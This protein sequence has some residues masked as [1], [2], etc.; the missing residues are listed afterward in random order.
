LA[1]AAAASEVTGARRTLSRE[2]AHDGQPRGVRDALKQ[3]QV[4]VCGPYHR[5]KISIDVDIVQ[6]YI[7]D[8]RTTMGATMTQEMTA[9]RIL[10]DVRQ[11]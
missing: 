3:A 5:S 6:R 9:D 2:L 4:G 11:R 1:H 7:D 10:E 8:H